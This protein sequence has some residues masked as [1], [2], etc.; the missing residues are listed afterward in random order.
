MESLKIQTQKMSFARRVNLWCCRRMTALQMR[1][2]ASR[3]HRPCRTNLFVI[4]YLQP[5]H[6]TAR[7]AENRQ[8]EIAD[9]CSGN[10]P[11]AEELDVPV[12]VLS[13]LS[14]EIE[15]DKKPPAAALGD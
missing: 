4:D 13:Q 11:L 9:I 10:Q 6:S 12:I 1:A 5:L 3:M 2:G 8:Q 7:R 15:R 14:R